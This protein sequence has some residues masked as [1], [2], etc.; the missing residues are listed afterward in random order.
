VLQNDV[1]FIVNCYDVVS[2]IF[3]V[4]KSDINECYC[5]DNFDRIY[6]LGL[7]FVRGGRLQIL[8]IYT[9]PISAVPYC[10][11]YYSMVV[12]VVWLICKCLREVGYV[13]LINWGN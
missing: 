7:H 5:V 13:L 9:L 3:A 11:K 2:P 1:N 4:C 12:L 6:I 8:L 10:E